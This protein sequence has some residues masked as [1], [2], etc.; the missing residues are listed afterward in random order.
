MKTFYV[1]ILCSKRNGTLYIGITSDLIK[2]IYEHKNG[3]VDG[4]TKKYNVHNLVWYEIHESAES[5]ITR[6]KQIKKWKRSWKMRRIE[7]SNPEWKDLYE[8]ICS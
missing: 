3:L 7:Q 6:E 8:A 5:A 1:H 2:R 4:F